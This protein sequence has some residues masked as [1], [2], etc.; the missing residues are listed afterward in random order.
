MKEK[1]TIAIL[2]IFIIL[3]SS[4]ASGLGIFSDFG[5]GNFEYESIRGKT[6]EI[7]GKGVYQHMSADVA[8]QGIKLALNNFNVIPVVFIIPSINIIPILSSILMIKNLKKQFPGMV[9]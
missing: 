2:V 8:I 5:T 4:V 1:N 6:I 7:F 3:I 9:N